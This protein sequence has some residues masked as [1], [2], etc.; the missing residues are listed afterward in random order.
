[1]NRFF[2]ILFLSAVT[3][4]AS[5]QTNEELYQQGVKYKA[6]YKYKEGLA[7]FQQL[8]KS[9][10]SNINYLTNASFFYSRAGHMLTNEKEQMKSY[11]TAEYLARKSIKTDANSAESHYVWALALGRINEHAGSSQKIANAKVIK[12]EAERAIALNPKHAGAYH[13]LGRWHR[14]IAGLSG[15]EKIAVNSM[16][17]GVPQGSSM[18]ESVKAFQ[19]AIL[20]EPKYML[21]QYELALTYNEMGK[22]AEAKAWLKKALEC[23]IQTPDD[24]QTKKDAEALLKKLGG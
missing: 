5:S 21:H 8:L 19:N 18:D 14:E 4:S 15:L 22:K 23:P 3:F 10:S 2:L 6:E 13:I 1:M 11:K 24:P 17:G 20:I 16:F 9:D 12:L 7:V